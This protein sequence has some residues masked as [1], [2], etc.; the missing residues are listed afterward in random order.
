[1]PKAPAET[2][3]A[4]LQRQEAPTLCAV[5][6]ELAEAHNAVKQRLVRLQLADHPDRLAAGFKR[7]LAARRR[8][9]QFH[10]YRESREYGGM[11][12]TLR[13]AAHF[14]QPRIFRTLSEFARRPALP[15]ALDQFLATQ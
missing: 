3:E 4:F 14:T 15:L 11:L 6:L 2:L 13:S 12:A 5:L 9:T 7:T 1:M 8:S 10:G